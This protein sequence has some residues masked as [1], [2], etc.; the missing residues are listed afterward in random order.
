[1]WPAR[2]QNLTLYMVAQLQQEWLLGTVPG[3]NYEHSQMWLPQINK[4]KNKFL[5]TTFLVS[6]FT[7]H[8]LPV[9]QRNVGKHELKSIHQ[10]EQ[11]EG[12]WWPL[13]SSLHKVIRAKARLHWNLPIH[14]ASVCHAGLFQQNFQWSCEL[15]A[16]FALCLLCQLL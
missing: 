3:E 4:L 11:L 14:Y 7:L 10:I 8:A 16:H 12:R 5:L 13:L 9:Q 2:V 15:P 1:M 6:L